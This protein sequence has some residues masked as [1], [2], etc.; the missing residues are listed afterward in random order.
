[1]TP[2][3]SLAAIALSSLSLAACTAET[4][5]PASV[6]GDTGVSE[7]G[8]IGGSKALGYPEAAIINMNS[9]TAACSGALI[10]PKVVLTAGHCVYK[11]TSFSIKVPYATGGLQTARGVGS[12]LYDWQNDSEYVNPKMHDIGL[13]FLDKPINLSQYPTLLSSPVA[14]NST[15]VNVGRINNGRLSNSDM[16]VSKPVTVRSASSIGFPYDYQATNVIESG[17]SGGPD[18]VTG[19]HKIAAVNSGG[20]STEVL[21]RVDLLYNWIQEKVASHGG[22]GTSG[23]DTAPE[24]CVHTPCA[25][26][27]VLTASCHPC[28]ASICA[29]DAYCCSTAWDAQCVSEIETICQKT[30][31]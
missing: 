14:N 8:I 1:M 31:S 11:M 4:S 19:T 15:L 22:T 21:A 27:T 5:N 17:D 3:K 6:E 18:F 2:L 28:V 26:G 9:G 24:Q 20:G 16:F 25:T 13:I 12:A 23:K 7:R 29:E 30:C 10:A